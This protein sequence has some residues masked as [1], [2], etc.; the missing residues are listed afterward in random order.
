MQTTVYNALPQLI[1]SE[2]AD[3]HVS[4]QRCHRLEKKQDR[5][6]SRAEQAAAVKLE[7]SPQTKPSADVFMADPSDELLAPGSSTNGANITAN[8]PSK[9]THPS[10]PVAAPGPVAPEI[11]THLVLGTN[12]IIKA[13]ERQTDELRLRIMVLGEAINAQS[14]PKAGGDGQRAGKRKRDGADLVQDNNAAD[15]IG[16]GKRFLPTA[17][18]D[19][20]LEENDEADVAMD[21]PEGG[22]G[23][24]PG[25]GRADALEGA[26]T[27]APTTGVSNPT[28]RSKD[29]AALQ[30]IVIPL[31]DI[32][33]QSLVA[34]IP[35]YCATYNTLAYQH[36]HLLKVARTRVPQ[37]VLDGLQSGGGSEGG[38]VE[39]VR[40]VPLGR[41]EAEMAAMA[42]LRRMACLGVRV[43]AIVASKPRVLC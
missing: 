43:S 3:Y 39:E 15:T 2:V 17:P 10:R 33:P 41:V 14:K 24:P 32:N 8:A 29:S 34:P 21:T 28:R 13:L 6:A 27:T 40:V 19:A 31:P 22:C 18:L 42:G 1:P 25:T 30:Y 7:E 4:R 37:S 35:A 16:G 12:E 26:S 23:V 36:D 38:P 20:D 5:K 11:L 9:G